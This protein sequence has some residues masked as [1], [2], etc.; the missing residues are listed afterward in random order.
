MRAAAE[1]GDTSCLIKTGR[2]VKEVWEGFLT[3]YL[4][5][6]VSMAREK[7]KRSWRVGIVTSVTSRLPPTPSMQSLHKLRPVFPQHMA[8]IGGYCCSCCCCVCSS[9]KREPGIARQ[10]WLWNQ[11]LADKSSWQCPLVVDIS[12]VGWQKRRW[13]YTFLLKSLCLFVCV[14][15]YVCVWT[16]LYL[17]SHSSANKANCLLLGWL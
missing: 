14:Y 17:N 10:T 9:E 13:L 6:S 1:S 15:V 16:G 8:S 7:A 2:G 11:L 3:D 12:V 4:D 5:A